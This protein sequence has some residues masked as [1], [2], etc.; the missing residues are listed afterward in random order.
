MAAPFGRGRVRRLFGLD[1][2]APPP[3]QTRQGEPLNPWTIPN[4]VGYVRLAVIPLFLVLAYGTE[5]GT[6]VLSAMVFW[7]IAAGDYLDGILARITGQYSRMGALLDPLVDRLTILAGAVVCWD[8][9]LLPR[10]ALALLALRELVMLFLAQYG[11]RHGVDIEVNWPGRISV[12]PIM[13]GIWLA[14]LAPGP[15]ATGLVIW[16]LVMAIIATVL[17]AR[18]GIRAVRGVKSAS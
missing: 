2:S 3:P 4:A 6:S 9:S 15:I 17:Y 7:A 14:L 5:D 13:G 10:W 12:F 16:G 18:S 8:F 1:R 11:L